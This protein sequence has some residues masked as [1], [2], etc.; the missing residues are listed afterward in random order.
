MIDD[1]LHKISRAIVNEALENNF[2]IVLRNLKRIR[3]T[4]KVEDSTGNLTMDFHIIG[5]QF[6]EFKAKW[7]RIKSSK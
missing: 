1:I 2:M 5:S 7:L 3:K 6:I 4:V